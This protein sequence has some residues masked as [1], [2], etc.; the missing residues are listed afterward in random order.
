MVQIKP[1][2]TAFNTVNQVE[3]TE[4]HAGQRLDNFL[5]SQLK[6]VPKAHIYRII[7]KGEVRV[8]KKR[9]K[10]LQKL[11]LGDV[12][13]I[14]PV[15]LNN[16]KSAPEPSNQAL[17]TL[18]KAIIYE[19][20]DLIV[21]NKPSGFAVHGGSGVS[22][23]VIE[24]FRQLRPREKRLELVHR[25]DKETSG[26]LILAKKT[27]VLRAF[28][29]MIR[30]DAIE[31]TYLALLQG[32]L[33]EDGFL[34]DVPLRKS[35]SPS[36]ERRV[37]V[38]PEGKPSKTRFVVSQRFGLACLVDVELLTGRTHQIR[39]H[40]LHLNHPIAGDEKYGN[41]KFNRQMRDFGLQRLF[42]HARKLRFQHPVTGEWMEP[43]AALDAQLSSVIR[44]L[45]HEQTL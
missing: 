25:L 32:Q 3:I 23:G 31:K 29:Q 34:V 30:E 43:V 45:Q 17:V 19:D 2:A 16:A 11:Q 39:V 1:K 40:S 20:K 7:R 15:R 9:C 22:Y 27:S 18:E 41:K 36:G 12:V 42:L 4:N 8:N 24:G 6:K 5:S 21:L 13:R 37:Y 44:R 28:H 10:P 14:P 33:A 38:D 26:C 35:V